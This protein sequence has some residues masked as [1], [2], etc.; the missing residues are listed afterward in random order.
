MDTRETAIPFS[1]LSS[2]FYSI[3]TSPS[4]GSTCI[5]RSVTERSRSARCI[6]RIAHG[7]GVKILPPWRDAYPPAWVRTW[8]QACLC[9]CAP[10]H[11]SPRTKEKLRSCA[12][13]RRCR[14]SSRR[15]TSSA[16]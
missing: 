11:R 16:E 10:P 7:L 13:G 12:G 4:L 1:F 14:I 15:P 2:L 8:V 6:A 3:S 5:E 9:A